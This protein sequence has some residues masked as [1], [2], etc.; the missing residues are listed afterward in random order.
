MTPE[1]QE[2]LELAI[3]FPE[4]FQQ[5]IESLPDDKFVGQ[6]EHPTCCTFA[7]FIQ[8]Y[9]GL[10]VRVEWDEI[11][12]CSGNNSWFFACSRWLIFFILDHDELPMLSSLTAS[13]AKQILLKAVS[14]DALIRAS[15]E[16]AELIQR[17]GRDRITPHKVD[18]ERNP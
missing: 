16:S 12:L 6:S 1:Q 3:A 2:Q 5:W 9:L 13:A 11:Q 15:G 14:D 10:Q 4:Q 17:L 7:N 18:K 8:D